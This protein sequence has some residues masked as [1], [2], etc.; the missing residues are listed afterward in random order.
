MCV[1]WCD[2]CRCQLQ[3]SMTPN[4]HVAPPVR[5]CMRRVGLR[6][7]RGQPWLGLERWT[8][9]GRYMSLRIWVWDTWFHILLDRI[10]HLFV[11]WPGSDHLGYWWK[12][13]LPVHTGSGALCSSYLIEVPA[14]AVIQG[15]A[16]SFEALCPLQLKRLCLRFRM[17]FRHRGQPNCHGTRFQNSF[18]GWP[19]N[20]Q[21]YVHRSWSSSQ[22]CGHMNLDQLAPRAALLIEGTAFKK[23]ARTPPA[24][25]KTWEGG[26]KGRG[27]QKIR[28]LLRRLLRRLL[29]RVL[30]L[31]RLP[32]FSSS[33]PAWQSWSVS[34]NCC[35]HIALHKFYIFLYQKQYFL[36]TQWENPHRVNP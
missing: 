1:P 12:R 16:A 14:R 6:S 2:S 17:T 31:L 9:K 33:A 3:A 13:P 21:E 10:Q 26:T 11:I 20:V 27:G 19:C 30:L 23:I 4:A 8:W 24:K 22:L 25:L 34:N 36:W 15:V 5:G 18:Q 32:L 7:S 29:L 28:L 35:S